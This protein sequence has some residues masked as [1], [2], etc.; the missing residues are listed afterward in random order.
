MNQMSK[1]Y[2]DGAQD[3]AARKPRRRWSRRQGGIAAI[4]LVVALGGVWKLVDKPQAQAQAAQIA[5]VGISAPLQRAVTQWDEYVG[6]F[7]PSQTVDIRPRVSGAVTAIHFQDGDYVRKGQLLFTI[8]QRPFRAALAEARASVASARSALLLAKNDYA[9][10]QRLTGDE[11][12]SASEVDSLRSRLQ[13]AQA[14]LAGA[15]A[16]ERSRALDVEFTQVRAPISGRVSD[17]R[18]DIG[19]L[20]SGAE[21]NGATLLTTV[22]KLDPIYFNFDASEALYLKSQRDQA[23]GGLVEVRLQ[24]E[25][26]YRHKGRLDFTDNGL[27]PRSGTIRIRAVFANP[28]NFLTPGLFGNMRLANGGKA[29]ALLVPDAAIQSDQ[30]RKTVLVVG[31]DD[32]VAAKPVELGPVVDGL[33]IIRSGLKPQDRIVI[34]N[35]QAA[36]PGAKVA[37]RP[38]TIRPAPAPVTPVD[39]VTPAAAQATFAR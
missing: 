38:A 1:I 34:T 9:R 35:V 21:G 24:D 18:V 8:D 4:A 6:R 30:A 23:D 14:E 20:V 32:S 7:A 22:N 2:T 37:T 33:R 19:N 28:D 25:A 27:D 15:Q 39:S 11:A 3:A 26:D 10:V 29:S 36:M 13:A 12:V 17:R 16:R 31:K 5:T